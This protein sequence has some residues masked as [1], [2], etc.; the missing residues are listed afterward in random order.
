MVFHLRSRDTHFSAEH[1]FPNFVAALGHHRK[2]GVAWLHGS[3][4]VD[5]RIPIGYSLGSVLASQGTAFGRSTAPMI[6]SKSK[7]PK[8]HS[9]NPSVVVSFGLILVIRSFRFLAG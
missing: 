1:L 6:L 2:Q 5:G 8:L 4:L 7:S 3:P 9:G